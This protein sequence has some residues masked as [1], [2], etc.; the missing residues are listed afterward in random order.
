M[1]HRSHRLRSVAASKFLLPALALAA[2]LT[3]PAIADAQ[4]KTIHA[5]MHSDLRVIDPGLTTA[6]ITRDHG[7]MVYDTL[8]AMD[9]KFKVQPQMADFKV[10]DDKL[11][12]TFTLRDGLKWHDGTPVTAEDCVASL[13]RWGQKD[14]MGQKLMDFTASLEATDAKTITLKLKEPYGLVLESIG[15]PSSLVPFMM[16]KRIAETPADKAIPEQI[17]SGPFKFVAA[18]FQ[19]GVKAVYVKNTDY[20]PRK[21]P[22]SWTSGGKVVK[23]DR[24]E[25]ITMPDGQTAINALQSGDIDFVEAPSFDILPVLKQDKELTIHTLSPLGFQTLG[26]MNFLYPPFD[27]V[28]I[29]R[30]A[31]LAMSQKPVL[32]ALVGNPD[33]YKVCGAVFGCD[34]PLATDVGSETLVKGN[35][36]AEAKKLLAESGY[37]GTPIALMAPGDVGSLKAQP[38][39]AAQLLREAGF[40]VDFQATDWQTVVTRR[41]S[42]KPP[43][44]GGWNMFFTNWAGPDILNPVANVSTG[45]KGKNGGWFGWPDDPKVEALRDKFARSTSPEEQK[46]LAEEIQKEVYDQVLYIPLGQYKAPS[47]WRNELTGV[48]DGPATPVF[49]NIEKKD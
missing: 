20:V 32:D 39:V 36:M 6:Y 47:V 4:T 1:L 30:A 38:I 23:V 27:N 42:Q 49:W 17:G 10:S 34:T 22:P 7:Y 28:K 18:E 2:S 15:K 26:R 41:A 5:V 11:T 13:K 3:L 19:P 37:D 31:F 45:G 24:V 12:Y 43:K 33:Y 21:E 8:L 25:W 14:G 16:P 35:G 44:D 46:K 29:R 40:K 9:S 48:L